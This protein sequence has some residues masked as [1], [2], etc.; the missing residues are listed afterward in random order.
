MHET[1]SASHAVRSPAAESAKL[2]E[3]LQHLTHESKPNRPAFD[4]FGKDKEANSCLRSP[5]SRTSSTSTST[6]TTSMSTTSLTI[7]KAPQPRNKRTPR[8]RSHSRTSRAFSSIGS[9]GRKAQ[10]PD[11]RPLS[12]APVPAQ[13]QPRVSSAATPKR[14]VSSVETWERGT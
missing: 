2:G 12:Y 7:A 11:S 6:S 4:N 5:H 10:A 1:A 14:H 8:A 13:V 9:T 3:K